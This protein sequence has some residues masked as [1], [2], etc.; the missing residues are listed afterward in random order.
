MVV[1]RESNAPEEVTQ[2]FVPSVRSGSETGPVGKGNMNVEGHEILMTANTNLIA[3]PDVALSVHG[4][5]ISLPKGMERAHAVEDISFDLR[6][7]QILCVIGESGSGKS[8][9]ANT[10]MGLLPKVISITAGSIQLEGREIVGMGPE[11]LRSPARPAGSRLRTPAQNRRQF[12]NM[13]PW[14][15]RSIAWL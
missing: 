5:T 2:T 4:P 8:V 6:R 15:V 14:T 10:I 12:G 3:Q 7:G 9:T 13:I 1:V 11:A